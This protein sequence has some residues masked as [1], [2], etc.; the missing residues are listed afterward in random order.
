VI[1]VHVIVAA[2][3]LQ[4]GVAVQ[5]HEANGAAGAVIAQPP[6]I[7]SDLLLSPVEALGSPVALLTESERGSEKLSLN[8]LFALCDTA[9]AGQSDE[10]SGTGPRIGVGAVFAKAKTKVDGGRVV[11]IQVGPVMLAPSANPAKE[12]EEASRWWAQRM[13]EFGDL[14]SVRTDPRSLTG[15]S[16]CAEAMRPIGSVLPVGAAAVERAMIRHKTA[17]DML[18]KLRDLDTQTAVSLQ[19]MAP[20]APALATDL[21][22]VVTWLELADASQACLR[23]RGDV[24]AADAVVADVRAFLKSIR[25]HAME[26][27]L[28]ERVPSGVEGF[29]S[30][31]LHPSWRTDSWSLVDPIVQLRAMREKVGAEFASLAERIGRETGLDPKAIAELKKRLATVADNLPPGFEWTERFE[32]DCE[33]H[34]RD[35]F[36]ANAT[37]GGV[38]RYPPF[39]PQDPV[40]ASIYARTVAFEVFGY[41]WSQPGAMPPSMV[42]TRQARLDQVLEPFR[43]ALGDRSLV[44]KAGVDQGRATIDLIERYL[45]SEDTRWKPWMVFPAAPEAARE[46]VAS[47]RSVVLDELRSLNESYVPALTIGGSVQWEQIC[48]ELDGVFASTGSFR[49]GRDGSRP[50]IFTDTAVVFWDGN[51][52]LKKQ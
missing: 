17:I 12:D 48:W 33:A 9:H 25:S 37:F 11:T 16:P 34:M 46:A 30:L 19:L 10:R 43:A 36:Q 29:A 45:A 38:P 7:R 20:P 4:S 23:L 41:A 50:W 24:K 26:A 13:R 49:A 15:D 31:T 3:I 18:V 2:I 47:L 44:S 40:V 32:D 27:L 6:D 52:S 21:F 39:E 14:D 1:T 28:A 42:E 51:V 8:R 35:A 22:E 5:R